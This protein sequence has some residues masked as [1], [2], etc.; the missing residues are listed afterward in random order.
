M[1]YS[2][3]RGVNN[4]LICHLTSVATGTDSP[5]LDTLLTRIARGD[6]EALTA[7]YNELHGAIYG[8]AYSL[9]GN[10][11]DAE[12]VLHDCFLAIVKS[13]GGYQSNGTPK[14]WIFTIA[15]NLCLQ[16]LRERKKADLPTPEEW[17]TLPDK[18]DTA[19]DRLTVR[20]CLTQLSEEDR[21]I[22]VLHAVS[23]FR[24]REIAAF[25]DMPLSTVLSKYNRALKKLKAILSA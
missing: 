16:K 19:D 24:H 9:V 13:V 3:E 5:S 21:Q 4:V 2:N 7:L 17:S 1:R 23:G 11:H 20:A 22:V 18:D 6:R 12:D 14:A 10:K 15:K 8:Y 25:L